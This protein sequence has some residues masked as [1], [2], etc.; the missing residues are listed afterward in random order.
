MNCEPFHKP[1][2]RSGIEVDLSPSDKDQ[3]CWGRK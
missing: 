3:F 1:D 2:A